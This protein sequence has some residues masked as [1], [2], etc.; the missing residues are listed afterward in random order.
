MTLKSGRIA[1][2]LALALS[3]AGCGVSGAPADADFAAIRSI[4]PRFVKGVEGRDA[5]ALAALY[6][7]AAVVLPPGSNP[8]RGR[9]AIQKYWQ[10]MLNGPLQSVRLEPREV[11]VAGDLA[12]ETGEGTIGLSAP[13]GGLSVPAAYVTIMKKQA[14]G[15]WKLTHDIWNLSAEAAPAQ[16]G[17]GHQD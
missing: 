15:S 11:R 2:T 9:A 3:G 4:S 12:Y 14:D 16:A 17:T 7:E 5:A 8:I 1:L 10:G 6:D 13:S